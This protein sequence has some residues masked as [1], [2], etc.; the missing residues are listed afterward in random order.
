MTLALNVF[1]QQKFERA[2]TQV[3]ALIINPAILKMRST[4]AVVGIARSTP[5]CEF[6][7]RNQ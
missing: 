5:V 4:A 3:R 1:E 7:Q 6:Q 2:V